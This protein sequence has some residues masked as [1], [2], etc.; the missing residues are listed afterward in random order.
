MF[1][2]W[3]EE[4]HRKQRMKDKKEEERSNSILRDLKQLTLT[5]NRGNRPI[6]GLYI[7]LT[8]LNA[9]DNEN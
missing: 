8:I 4:K 5:L 1:S 2:V 7:G 6:T 9:E 3:K